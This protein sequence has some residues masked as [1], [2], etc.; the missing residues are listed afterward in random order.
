M[1]CLVMLK[2]AMIYQTTPALPNS[3]HKF[4]DDKTA[5]DDFFLVSYL[6]RIKPF[7]LAV[8]QTPHFISDE[9]IMQNSV[10]PSNMINAGQYV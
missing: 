5:L 1:N 7:S 4:P 3:H 2:N 9:D 6:Y 10:I 8:I